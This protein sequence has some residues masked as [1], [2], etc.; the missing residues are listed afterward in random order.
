MSDTNQP[1]HR[2]MYVVER[3]GQKDKMTQIGADWPHEN[4][5][6]STFIVDVPLI[7]QPGDRLVRLEN[8]PR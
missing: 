1:T 6:G 3:K 8:K 2:V 7:L 5:R 4:G